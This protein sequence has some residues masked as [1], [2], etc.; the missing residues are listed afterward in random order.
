MAVF[1]ETERLSLRRLTS[2]DAPLLYE[3]DSD[4]EVMRHIS[5]GVPTPLEQIENE[6]LPRWLGFYEIYGGLGVWA[7]HEKTS[8]RFLGWFHLRPDRYAPDEQ[9]LGYRLR[10]DA[11]G[12]GYATEGARALID[13][14][15]HDLNIE[16]IIAR[17]LVGNT[18]S[19]RVM[20]KCGMLFEEAFTYPLDLLPGWSEAERAAVKYGLSRL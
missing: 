18:A 16:R 20:E 3:L 8:D 17:T 7:A 12:R 13:K 14:T 9:E 19:R 15:F 10:R 1:L 11:W 2:A 4:S 5:K 6:I